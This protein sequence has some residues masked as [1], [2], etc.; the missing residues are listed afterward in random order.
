M[1]VVPSVALISLPIW[2]LVVLIWLYSLVPGGA[3]SSG[4]GLIGLGSLLV[5]VG[6]IPIFSS[7]SLGVASK[8]F[9][10]LMYFIICAVVMFVVGWA[11]LGFFGLIKSP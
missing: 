9:L 10:F 11:A 8:T 4:N 6:G 5:F 2:G 1:G 7:A 3:N